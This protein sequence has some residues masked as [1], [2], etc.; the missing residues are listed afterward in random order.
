MQF[1]EFEMQDEDDEELAS[2]DA[3]EYKPPKKTTLRC[4][5]E[6]IKTS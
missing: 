4:P 2:E 3:E 5:E 1:E 6:Q